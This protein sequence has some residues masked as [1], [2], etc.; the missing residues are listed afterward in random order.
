M[1]FALQGFCFLIAG[2]NVSTF[3]ERTNFSAFF[4]I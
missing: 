2:A 1:S 4:F 3:L